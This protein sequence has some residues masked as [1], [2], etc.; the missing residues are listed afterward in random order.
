MPR[1]TSENGT[2]QESKDL[3]VF[4]ILRDSECAECRKELLARD[5]LFIEMVVRYA[6]PVPT[7][8]T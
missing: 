6:S 3:V 1:K 8:T 7:S 5:F 2:S 4:E